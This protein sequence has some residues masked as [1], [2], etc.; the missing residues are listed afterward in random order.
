M[1]F[2]C[3]FQ[4]FIDQVIVI[5]RKNYPNAHKFHYITTLYGEGILFNHWNILVK[6]LELKPR[7]HG[8]G[9]EGAAP[10]SNVARCGTR[11]PTRRCHVYIFFFSRIRVDVARFVPNRLRFTLNR[12]NSA[13][14]EPYRPCQVI[15]TDDQYGRNK[16]KSAV[17]MA[18]KSEI[19]TSEVY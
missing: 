5:I 16:P 12:A 9:W 1:T 14:I 17:N 4:T 7:K 10:A 8:R 19:I 6:Q 3:K 2:I 18:E 15:S 11:C 13:K